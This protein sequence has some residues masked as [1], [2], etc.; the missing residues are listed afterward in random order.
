ML[1]VLSGSGTD[2]SVPAEQI[3]V[4]ALNTNTKVSNREIIK[5]CKWNC[6]LGT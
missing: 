4:H 5:T 3:V 6:L 2:N 1:T